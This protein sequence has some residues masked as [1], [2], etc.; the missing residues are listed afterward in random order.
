[1]S[2]CLIVHIIDDDEAVRTSLGFA[3]EVT[4]YAVETYADAAAFLAAPEGG[5]GVLICD[6]RMPGINGIELTRMMRDR[7]SALPIIL[8]TGHADAMLQ[9]EALQ[10]GAAAVLE[11]PVALG[12][13]VETIARVGA[14]S[15]QGLHCHRRA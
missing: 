11:K 13:I 9:A 14:G 15:G 7:G 5:P 4:G 8:M 1:M 6:V 10:A 12:T 2:V 3:L